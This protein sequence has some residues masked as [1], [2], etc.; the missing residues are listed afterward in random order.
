MRSRPRRRVIARCMTIANAKPS[1]S[2]M[3]TVMTVMN[4]VTPRLY[5]NFSSVKIVA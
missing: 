1:T 5:Q 2:S 3:R 4:S